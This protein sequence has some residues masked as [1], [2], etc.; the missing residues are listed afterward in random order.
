VTS[1]EWNWRITEWCIYCL[2]VKNIIYIYSFSNNYSFS[3]TIFN[4]IKNLS[5]L[6]FIII[7]LII[8]I[9][10]SGF[11]RV[12]LDY[13]S[14]L[15]G[16]RWRYPQDQVDYCCIMLYSVKTKHQMLKRFNRSPVKTVLTL[17]TILTILAVWTV[18]FFT[19]LTLITVCTQLTSFDQFSDAG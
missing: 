7:I 17:L 15:L 16:A 8:I 13:L 9:M 5:T 4:E 14:M 12:F 6:V 18:F 10:W 19:V 11:T 1:S 2:M 3:N